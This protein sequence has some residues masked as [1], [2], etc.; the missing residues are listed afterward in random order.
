MRT[1]LSNDPHLRFRFDALFALADFGRFDVK[2]NG[3]GIGESYGIC[4]FEGLQ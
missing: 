4:D 2:S 3:A 1:I